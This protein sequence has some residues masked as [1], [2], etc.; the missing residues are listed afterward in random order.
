MKDYIDFKRKITKGGGTSTS[1]RISI[2]EEII[3]K[4]EV[5]SGDKI[6]W[7]L[8]DNNNKV[9]IIFG[10]TTQEDEEQQPKS[11]Q[12]KEQHQEQQQPPQKPKK[13]ST[14]IDKTT[15]KQIEIK[16]KILES[17]TTDNKQ[18]IINLQ[19]NPSL[20]IAVYR[21]ETKKQATKLG[22]SSRGEEEIKDII[23]QLKPCTTEEEIK[24][25]FNKYK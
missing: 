23:S 5:K 18:F 7:R 4:M 8:Y 21:E 20:Q 9:E 15:Q 24:E 12:Q 19:E 17:T 2:P 22:A 1:Y 6:T 11:S 25:I 16:G 10:D 3:Q 13:V 14:N